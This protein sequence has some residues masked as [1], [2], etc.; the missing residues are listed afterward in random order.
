VIDMEPDHDPE[1]G[2]YETCVRF[3]A[4]SAGRAHSLT[5]AVDGSVYA[6][7]AGYWG[8]LGVGHD[9]C[10]YTPTQI[11]LYGERAVAVAAGGKHSLV[12]SQ[13]G[14]LYS[15]GCSASGVLGHGDSVNRLVPRL[16]AGL[17]GVRVHAV[18]AGLRHSLVLSEAGEVYA[19]GCG[20]SGRLGH[21]SIADQSTPLRIAGLQGVRVSSVVA[22]DQISLAVRPDGV[23]YGW[24]CEDT[25]TG[26]LVVVHEALGMAFTDDPLMPFMYPW[27]ELRLR[28]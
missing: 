13:S 16:V 12:V 4:V 11:D 23:V 20:K 3:S 1:M 19:F 27:S 15:F 7:G 26:S 25:P 22:G 18:A 14:R 17:N 24:G 21:G 2:C 9:G 6:F 28:V 10:R 5:V 8:R